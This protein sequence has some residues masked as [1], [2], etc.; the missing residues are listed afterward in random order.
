MT[1]FVITTGGRDR[2]VLE[3][4]GHYTNPFDE[5]NRVSQYESLW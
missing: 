3:R 5:Q 4:T 2:L 1:W